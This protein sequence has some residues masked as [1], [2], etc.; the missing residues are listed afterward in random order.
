MADHGNKHSSVLGHIYI[1]DIKHLLFVL[2]CVFLV[3]VG[4]VT[5]AAAKNQRHPPAFVQLDSQSLFRCMTVP[6]TPK[7]HK[8]LKK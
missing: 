8:P 4:R 1:Y 3:I 2:M 6:L 5:I 7:S